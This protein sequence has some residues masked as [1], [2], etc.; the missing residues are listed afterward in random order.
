[1]AERTYSVAPI[2]LIPC[3]IICVILKIVTVID[4]IRVFFTGRCFEEVI[5]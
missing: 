2:F 1:M 5:H 4:K 3:L